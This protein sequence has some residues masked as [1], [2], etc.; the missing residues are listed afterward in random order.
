[1]TSSCRF[2]DLPWYHPTLS[3]VMLNIGRDTAA[4]IEGAA[5]ADDEAAAGH[6]PR[7]ASGGG[8]PERSD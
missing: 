8:G 4:R 1:M 3:E 7:R 5:A 2:F 6:P